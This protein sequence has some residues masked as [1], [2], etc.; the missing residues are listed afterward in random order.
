VCEPTGRRRCWAG[1]PLFP[2]AAAAA[3]LQT[4]ANAN[5]QSNQSNFAAESHSVAEQLKQA[6]L[7]Q[8]RKDKAF[9]TIENQLK[10]VQDEMKQLMEVCAIVAC[11]IFSVQ[12]N[13]LIRH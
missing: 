10:A 1:R 8:R 7:E 11:V 9:K 13:A 5:L 4:A 2:P 3:V 12:L 6:R